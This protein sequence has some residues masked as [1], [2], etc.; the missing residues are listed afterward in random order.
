MKRANT[1]LVFGVLALVAMG[2]GSYKG[3]HQVKVSPDPLEV[4]GDTIKYAVRAS[5]PPKTGFGKGMVINGALSLKGGAD[6]NASYPAGSVKIA[7]EEVPNVDKDGASKSW[8]FTMPYQEAMNG[9]VM[10]GKINVAKGTSAPK[11]LGEM[12]NLAQ[13]CITTSK[14]IDPN[15]AN[16]TASMGGG[17]ARGSFFRNLP[18]SYKQKVEVTAEAKFQFPKDVFKIQ[19]NQYKKEDIVKIGEFLKMKY[20]QGKINI[21]GF[22]SPEGKY[23]RNQFLSINRSREVQKWLVEQLKKEGYNNYLD[24][25]FFRITTTSEDWEGFKA[26][27]DQTKYSE[28]VK[29]QIIEIISAGL[30]EDEKERKIMALVGGENRVEN[31]LAPLRRATILMEANSIVRTDEQVD[32]MVSQFVNGSMSGDQLSSTFGQEEMLYAATRTSDP[33]AKQKVLAEYTKKYPSDARGFNNLGVAYMLSDNKDMAAEAFMK[34]NEKKANDPVVLAN[35]ARVQMMRGNMA[36]AANYGDAANKIAPSP[37]ASYVKGVS[38]A[39]AG[40]YSQAAQ[41][42]EAAKDEPGAKYNS[43]VSKLLMNDLA[44]AKADLDGAVKEDPNNAAAYYALAIVGARSGDTN[45]MLVNLKN[46][47]QKDGKMSDKAAKDLEFRQYFASN[48]FKAAIAK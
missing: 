38:A 10:V 28:D 37:I 26:N 6:A 14:M 31:I 27:L 29:R 22:A 15:I 25:N 1:L 16:K 34:A 2:C 44:G 12:G 43:G 18:H 17:T 32:N 24:S 46:S 20:E 39:K 41:Q 4:H 45:I 8:N 33:A 42:F 11:D 5:V 36:D 3:G 30:D 21:Q 23:A 47:V 40:K 9:S 13:C 48:E 19:A 35:I 7:F